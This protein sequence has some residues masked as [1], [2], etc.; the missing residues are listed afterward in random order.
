VVKASHLPTAVELRERFRALPKEQRDARQPYC[1]RV[2][3]A[4]SWLE[5]AESM[6]P[7]DFE[8]R[9]ISGWIGF[10]ALYGR[11]DDQNKAW[12]EWEALETFLAHVWRL[13]HDNRIRG[14]LQHKQ[15]HV[16][17]LIEDKYLSFDFWRKGE[18]AAARVHRELQDAMARY[19]TNRMASV[20]SVL[21][22]RLYVMR[23][24]VFHGASTKGSKLNRYT[25]Q[26]SA[27]ILQELLPVM[28]SVMIDHGIDEDWG[29]I[30]FP[31]VD[32]M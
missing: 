29:L 23:N 13:D 8:G 26:R 25:L 16:L 7:N 1:I 11:L 24:Q 31:P 22:N 17:K 15:L 5:R 9:F 28:I 27:N 21:F 6:P 10:N 18:R 20:L 19:G 32:S 3:R 4:L 30:C 14:L 2:W 12:G